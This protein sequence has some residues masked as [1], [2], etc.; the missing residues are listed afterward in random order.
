MKTTAYKNGI[1]EVL[2]R[3]YFKLPEEQAKFVLTEINDMRKITNAVF[4]YDNKTSTIKFKS[5]K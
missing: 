5:V 1:K 2:N 4:Y 3:I